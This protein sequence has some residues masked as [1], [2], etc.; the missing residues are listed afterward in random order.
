MTGL[1]SR[2]LEGRD[3]RAAADWPADDDR[4]YDGT[5]TGSYGVAA[6]GAVVT[7]DT[8][9]KVS[10]VFACVRILAES[11]AQ[12]PLDIYRRTAIGKELAPSHPLYELLHDQPNDYQTS[13]E[14]REMLMGHLALRGNGYSRIM[15]GA[16]GAVDRLVP[17]H[18]DRVQVEVNNGQGFMPVTASTSISLQPGGRIR[19]VHWPS[20]GQR[21]VLVDEEVFHVRG[22]SSNGIVGMSVLEYA[23]NSMGLALAM[24]RHGSMLFAQGTR[25]SGVL[26]TDKALTKD[27]YER[28]RSSWAQLTGGT[29]NAHKTAILEQGLRWQQIGL[30]NDD[31]Q[32][33]DARKMQVTDIARW[34]RVPPHMI[35][36]LERATFANI[37][38]Q[39]IEFVV[40]CLLPWLVR[41]E[42]AIR[43]DLIVAVGA[44]FAKFDVKALLRGDSKAQAE[45]LQVLIN[46]GVITRN[47]A[48]TSLDMNTLD[49]L[50]KPLQPLNMGI[51]GEPL[52]LDK[53]VEAAGALVRAG[54]EPAEATR[55]VG[56]PE[57][58]HLGLPPVT[59]QPPRKPP[60]PP[61]GNAE[62]Q[63]PEP[64]N[65]SG[66]LPGAEDTTP[67]DAAPPAQGDATDQAAAEGADPGSAAAI[68]TARRLARAA[69]QRLV[70]KEQAAL[71]AIARRCGSSSATFRA[72]VAT[73]YEEHA[74]AVAEALG[75]E[76][77]VAEQYVAEQ[78][79]AVVAG[80]VAVLETWE[81]ERA[82][83]LAA[84]ALGEVA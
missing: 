7:P 71:L 66:D 20:S 62:G 52:P 27:G 44:Y 16:R 33:V 64:G 11:V 73:F 35:G 72:K 32:F 8:A 59:L 38:Q 17:L 43:R 75:L 51:V 3:R 14:Y 30:T 40:Y 9:M 47:E 53:K 36:D 41:W 45:A 83:A 81:T 65:P 58:E 1:I 63:P 39:S 57:M 48:R 21:E 84:L 77:A 34:F 56:L 61:P 60:E 28:V 6:S 42:Q 18:P 26:S 67:G 31:A 22:L 37:E 25:P 69:A 13:F 78:R 5:T 29:G 2:L 15:P 23:R 74:P 12:L 79:R 50:D 82:Q 80:G 55:A 54:W 19:Y 24:E 10:A 68:L 46:A 70:R 76:P 49:G 4:W